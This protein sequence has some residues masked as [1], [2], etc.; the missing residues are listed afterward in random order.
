M[1]DLVIAEHRWAGAG[2][3]DQGI[4][5]ARPLPPLPPPITDPEQITRLDIRRRQRLGGIL[6]AYNMPLELHG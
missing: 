4:A 6:N 3:P 1:K 2:R 5:N